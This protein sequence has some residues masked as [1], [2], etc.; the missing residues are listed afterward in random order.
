[1]Q[2]SERDQIDH[3]LILSL[4]SLEA[5]EF[6]E[7]LPYFENEWNKYRSVYDLKGVA[8]II[9]K[10]SEDS[11]CSL[12][13]NVAKLLFVLVYLK[14]NPLQ[15]YQ[16][17]TFK[18][19]Q[20]KVSQWLKILLPVWEKALA[21]MDLLPARDPDHLYLALQLIAGQAVYLDA[22]ERPVSRSVDAEKQQH[23]YSGKKKRHTNKNL[24]ISSESG[25]VLYLSATVTGSMHDKA[26]AD[27]ME[28]KFL[29]GQGILADSGFQGYEPEGGPE[30]CLPVKKPR[31]G[32]LSDYDKMYNK[33]LASLRVKVEHV[34]AGIK[35][36]RIVKDQIKLKS[37]QSRDRV[38]LI[39]AALQNLRC[40]HR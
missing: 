16:G 9:S 33:L 34:I 18:M 14:N 10:S 32:E 20:G 8:R 28:L 36:L 4:T 29:P 3:R 17:F 24:I 25:K 38:M 40:D 2:T 30:L 7:I 23:E 31:N 35:K 37:D 27:E 21:K 15:S 13:G 5:A 12:K 11:R 1:M 22:T 19:S 26:L 39:A 6:F